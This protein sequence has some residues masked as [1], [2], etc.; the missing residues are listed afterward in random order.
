MSERIKLPP[1]RPIVTARLA[2]P[3]T[4]HWHLTTGFG[5][6]GKVREIFLDHA[7]HAGEPF[8]ALIHDACI[9]FSRDALQRGCTAAELA[10]NL[11]E[12]PPSLFAQA[13]TVA[14]ALEADFGPKLLHGGSDAACDS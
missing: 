10:R 11:S 13:F 6:D 9:I 2:D 12:R 8:D 7:G 1:R 4:G 3:L 5:L 14:A